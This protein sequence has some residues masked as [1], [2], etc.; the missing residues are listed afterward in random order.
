L[1]KNKRF[2]ILTGLSPIISLYAIFFLMPLAIM[3]SLTFLTFQGGQIREILTL[4]NYLVFARN[5]VFLRALIETLRL[6]GAVSVTCII[7]GYPVA[8]VLARSPN[9][10]LRRL[11]MVMAVMPLFVSIVARSF[12]WLVILSK[13]GLVNNVLMSLGIVK[14]PVK[15][16]L[17]TTGVYIGLVHILLPFAIFSIASSL[18]NIDATLEEAAK[19]L[20]ASPVQTFMRVTFPLSLPGVI[21]GSIL[22]FSLAIAA[23]VTPALLGGGVVLSLPV[24][25]YDYAVLYLNWPLA[26]TLAVILLFASVTLMAIY[27][28]I[29]RIEEL[30]GKGGGR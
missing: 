27:L 15:F 4:E 6:G 30:F 23:F 1:P 16:V 18:E 19:S 5:D 26:G 13:Q 29:V 12:G 8:Y 9:L 2:S 24:M 21:A 20:G 7:L 25:V 28:R 14:E 3:I 17:N 10:H 22:T 11:I